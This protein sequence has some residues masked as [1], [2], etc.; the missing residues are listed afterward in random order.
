MKVA[1]LAAGIHATG[2]R[3]GELVWGPEDGEHPM[4]GKLDV[5]MYV[6]GEGTNRMM[7][8]DHVI[9]VGKQLVVNPPDILL[10]NFVMLELILTRPSERALVEAARGLRFLVLDELHT[11][12]GRQGSDVALLCRRARQGFHAPELQYIGTS[13]TLASEGTEA[14]RRHE[15]AGVAGLLELG[16]GL[17]GKLGSALG[18]TRREVGQCQR[19]LN[20]R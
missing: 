20:L 5:G 15:I 11:Y 7:G 9:D 16:S 19:V 12:R 13:A 17:C 4:R 14:E 2:R 3:I 1:T 6:G 18:V 8:R 10:T